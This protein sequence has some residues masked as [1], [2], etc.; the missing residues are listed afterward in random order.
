MID[1]NTTALNQH[2]REIDDASGAEL[3]L[4]KAK[5]EFSN[6]LF[7]GYFTRNYAV[8]DEVEELAS[9]EGAINNLLKQL[10][11]GYPREGL[12]FLSYRDFI[13][14]VCDEI[15]ERADDII[16]VDDHRRAYGL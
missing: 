9:E 3:A 4:E 6:D 5:Q 7:D 1:G 2:Q 8:I 11:Y 10:R 15:S 12:V 13:A 14:E 16:A